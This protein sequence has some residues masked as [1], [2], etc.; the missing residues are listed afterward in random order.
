[1][2]ASFVDEILLAFAER[3]GDQ[4]GERVSQ[5]EHAVQCAELAEAAGASEALT[6]AA[7]LH[8]YGHFFEGRGDAAEAEG[9]DAKHEAHGAKLLSQWFP[10]EVT[11][12]VALHVAAKRYLCA[13][14]PGYFEGLSDAS[15]LSLALQGGPFTTA[16]RMR[17]ERSR[18]A[19]D[20]VKLR[21]W[22]DAAK[23]IGRDV[24][25][26]DRYASLLVR[27]AAGA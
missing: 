6:A 25:P 16:Q 3:G 22:D 8:D 5:L 13:A 20:T 23:V 26:V 18:F 21:R 9:R 4:Y 1:M 17:F 19:E 24:R 2:S 14:E 27:A 11:G 15:K 10:P 7:L 12:P